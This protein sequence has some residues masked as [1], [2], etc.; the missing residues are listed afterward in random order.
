M[1]FFLKMTYFNFPEMKNAGRQ[2]GVGATDGDGILTVPDAPGAST[3]NHRNGNA[4]AY[5]LKQLKVKTRLGAVAIHAGQQDFARAPS[6]CIRN[7]FQ[8]IFAGILCSP[9]NKNRPL[10]FHALGIDSGYNALR[11]KLAGDLINQ[12]GISNNGAIEGNLVSSGAE[13][14]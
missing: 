9:R 5:S 10:V 14:I 11:A 1:K 4:L 8:S 6:L 3:G 7:P 2:Y 12:A 13:D